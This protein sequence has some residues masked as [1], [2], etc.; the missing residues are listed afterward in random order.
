LL[1][2]LRFDLSSS[3]LR[4]ESTQAPLHPQTAD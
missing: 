1:E 4:R 3:T 2:T